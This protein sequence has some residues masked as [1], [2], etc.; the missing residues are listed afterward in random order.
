[1]RVRA[2]NRGGS[3]AEVRLPRMT[4]EAEAGVRVAMVLDAART[5]Q[6]TSAEAL[7]DLAD[8]ATFQD[9]QDIVPSELLGACEVRLALV[10]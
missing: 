2:P 6:L 1:M 8:Q 4:V 5:L 3:F 10:P 9:L 7:V